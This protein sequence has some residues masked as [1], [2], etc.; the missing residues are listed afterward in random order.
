[1]GLV[2]AGLF[3]ATSPKVDE[4]PGSHCLGWSFYFTWMSFH[5]RA[6]G[7][8]LYASGFQEFLA[9]LVTAHGFFVPVLSI[10]F[11]IEP[12]STTDSLSGKGKVA[13]VP[14]ANVKL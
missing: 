10:F 9:A 14:D 8:L 4:G 12:T 3:L 6:Y 1:M 13:A 7:E 5:R 11:L 2:Y